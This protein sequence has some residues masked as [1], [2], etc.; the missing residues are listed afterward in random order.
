MGL[1]R[2]PARLAATA[3]SLGM[4]PAGEVSVVAPA[5]AVT[6]DGAGSPSATYT[7]PVTAPWIGHQPR[8]RGLRP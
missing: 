8:N 1:R 5:G 4:L 7:N 6:K 2:R 3:L